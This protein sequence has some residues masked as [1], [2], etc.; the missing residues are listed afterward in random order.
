MFSAGLFD[1]GGLVVGGERK[2]A[3]CC[4]LDQT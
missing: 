2:G 3:R 1:K 4:V